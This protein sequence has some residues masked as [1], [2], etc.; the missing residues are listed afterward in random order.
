MFSKCSEFFQKSWIRSGEYK[1]LTDEERGNHEN[2]TDHKPICEF[3]EHSQKSR[4]EDTVNKSYSSR[5]DRG[6]PQKKAQL[7]NI[8]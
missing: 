2:S 5:N 1:L 7:Q 8:R 4:Q 3:T 6:V